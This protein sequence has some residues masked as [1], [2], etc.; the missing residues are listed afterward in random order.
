MNQPSIT[1]VPYDDMAEWIQQ[2][3]RC[4][5][6]DVVDSLK[7]QEKTRVQELLSLRHDRMAVS[8]FTFYRGAALPMAADLATTPSRGSSVLIS[9]VDVHHEG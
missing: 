4:E 6:R 1:P 5:K 3:S 8:E 2:P 9:E 7:Q